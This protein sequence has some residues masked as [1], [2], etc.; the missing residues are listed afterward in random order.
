MKLDVTKTLNTRS[1]EPYLRPLPNDKTEPLTIGWAC[2][3]ALDTPPSQG[4]P[5]SKMDKL[6]RDKLAGRI[7]DAMTSK[8]KTVELAADDQ[9][10][11]TSVLDRFLASPRA[12][13][14]AIRL[15]DPAAI[16]KA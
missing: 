6:K 12:L 16:E 15:I 13:A 14:E 10:L 5:L 1:G 8:P 7:F 2:V 4:E 11:L 3:E 9:V